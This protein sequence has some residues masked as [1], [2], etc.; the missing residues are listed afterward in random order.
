[1]GGGTQGGAGVGFPSLCCVA[2]RS[3]WDRMCCEG[4]T[5]KILL[6]S[7]QYMTVGNAITRNR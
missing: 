4:H 6:M 1:V 3:G 7:W 5:Y 2:V